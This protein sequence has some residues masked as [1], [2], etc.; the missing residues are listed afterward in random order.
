VSTAGPGQPSIPAPARPAGTGPSGWHR[1]GSDLA[2]LAADIGS[3]QSDAVITTDLARI[4]RTPADT[5]AFT[6]HCASH[7]AHVETIDD[8][9]GQDPRAAALRAGLTSNSD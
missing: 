8:A 1:P 9:P 7:G 3:G 4:S 2:R 5:A 6:A